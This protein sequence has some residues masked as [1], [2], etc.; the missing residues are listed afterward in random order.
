MSLKWMRLSR[1]Q[2]AFNTLTLEPNSELN[3]EKSVLDYFDFGWFGSGANFRA[4]YTPVI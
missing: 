4:G 1:L 2:K 3:H